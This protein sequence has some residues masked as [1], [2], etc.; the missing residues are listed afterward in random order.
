LVAVVL[1]VRTIL[2]MVTMAPM[3]LALAGRG[4]LLVMAVDLA[5]HFIKLLVLVV[6]EAVL[7]T[8][9]LHQ[10]TQTKVH[11]QAGLAMVVTELL[12]QMVV[13][14]MAVA[15]AELLLR[16]AHKMV[17]MEQLLALAEQVQ[18]MLAVAVAVL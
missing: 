14:I 4:Q 1:A 17:G 7:V 9:H 15:V 16:Q 8:I 11:I 5:Q 2:L 3:A 6:L 10:I 18:H 12:A 13:V